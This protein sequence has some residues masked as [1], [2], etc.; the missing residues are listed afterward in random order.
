MSLRSMR[1][2]VCADTTVPVRS[3][4]TF[5]FGSIGIG[6]QT[7]AL[8]VL[9]AWEF[10][11]DDVSPKTPANFLEITGILGHSGKDESARKIGI[12]ELYYGG[13]ALVAPFGKML[14]D[15]VALALGAGA[16]L[17]NSRLR[18]PVMAHI[19]YTFLGSPHIEEHSEY[20]PNDCAFRLPGQAPLDY[21]SGY[22]ELTGGERDSTVHLLHEK[23]LVKESFRPFLFAEGGPI[24]DT[25]FEGSG[26]DP[27]LNPDDYNEYFFGGGVGAPLFDVLTV[28]LGYRY[29]R[30]NLRTPCPACADKMIL[31]TNIVHSILLKLGLRFDW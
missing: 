12:S 21:P 27:S 11:R 30:L 13:E 7:L 18:I 24:F 6:G 3:I 28:S 14:G 19:R 20:V 29:M 31:N 16:F 5:S 4:A 2:N 1:G 8:P 17:E 25:G 26:A 9:P 23:K 22:T 10:I 15:D